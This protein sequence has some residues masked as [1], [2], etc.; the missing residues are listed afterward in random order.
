MSGGALFTEIVTSILSFY[1]GIAIMHR[2]YNVVKN[3]DATLGESLTMAAKKFFP[4]IG[5][6]II[7]GLAIMVLGLVLYGIGMLIHMIL[8]AG[9]FSSVVLVCWYVIAM[10]IMIYTI[11]RLHFYFPAIMND[12]LGFIAALKQSWR[13]VGQHWWQTVF[14]ILLPYLLA[15]FVTFLAIVLAAYL[16]ANTC[17]VAIL[18]FVGT[19]IFLPW[20]NS[21]FVLQYQNLKIQDKA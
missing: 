10:I 11:V 21:V 16:G 13:L 14:V 8:P 3:K 15:M 18:G 9:T 6:M 19:L 7:A 12:N 20:I 2:I 4:V 17:I 5:A 1:L